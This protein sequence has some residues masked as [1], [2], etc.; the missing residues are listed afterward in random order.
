[1]RAA[2][3]K[4]CDYD[5]VVRAACAE[6]TLS[7]IVAV[8]DMEANGYLADLLASFDA[9]DCEAGRVEYVLADDCSSDGSL[10]QAVAWAE[11]R[12]DATV[13]HLYENMR[14]GAARNRAIDES[15]GRWFSIVDADDA[16]SSDYAS[17]I[18]V[19]ADETG[20]DAI[21]VRWIQLADE[22]M[23]PIAK[24]RQ[25]AAREVTPHER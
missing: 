18:L 13:I 16:V 19:A 9:Q 3:G 1:M 17:S 21:V 11:G 14:Q 20:A 10:A 12:D 7:V 25:E 22:G 15:R 4:A 6:P 23:K 5:V 8:H 24:T 2:E